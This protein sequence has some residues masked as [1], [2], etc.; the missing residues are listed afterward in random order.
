VAIDSTVMRKVDKESNSRLLLFSK[1]EISGSGLRN[2]VPGSPLEMSTY[3]ILL[4]P[5]YLVFKDRFCFQLGA[6]AY[7]CGGLCA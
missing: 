1:D 7:L 3:V 2:L 5:F 6:C 4:K